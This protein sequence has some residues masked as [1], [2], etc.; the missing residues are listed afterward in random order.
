MKVAVVT[1]WGDD[2]TNEKKEKYGL[3]Y[4]LAKPIR[5]VQLK[6]LVGEVLQFKLK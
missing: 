5:M 1:G 4:V 6:H 2:V 3:G